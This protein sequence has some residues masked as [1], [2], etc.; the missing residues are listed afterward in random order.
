M[1]GDYYQITN[2]SELLWFAQQVNSGN[3]AINAQLTQDIDLSENGEPT[4][5]TPIGTSLNA[6]NGVFDGCG[7]TVSGYVI[8]NGDDDGAS[9]F[10]SLR[11][12]FFYNVSTDGVVQNLTVDGDISLV[13]SK[14]F[15]SKT[16]SVYVGGITSLLNGRIYNSSNTGDISIAI[17]FS[18]SRSSELSLFVGGIAAHCSSDEGEIKNCSNSGTIVSNNQFDLNKA[19]REP[20]NNIVGGIVGEISLGVVSGCTNSGIVHA[21]GAD[22]NYAGG[23]A[24]RSEKSTITACINAAE[25]SVVAENVSTN[26]SSASEGVTSAGGISG[27]GAGTKAGTIDGCVNYGTVAVSGTGKTMY[28][29]GIGGYLKNTAVTSSSNIGSVSFTDAVEANEAD[30]YVGGVVGYND[31]STKLVQAKLTNCVNSGSVTIGKV[32]GDSLYAGGIVG[33]CES[34]ISGCVNSGTITNDS[35]SEAKASGGVVG[36]CVENTASVENSTWAEETAESGIG[37]N[38]GGVSVPE[39][40]PSSEIT[41]KAV[42]TLAFESSELTLKN[43]ATSTMKIQTLPAASA[44]FAEH[45]KITGVTVEPEGI[46][47]TTYNSDGTISLT[48]NSLGTATLTVTAELYAMNYEDMTID[49]SA[50]STLTLT[51]RVTVSDRSSEGLSLS[52]AALTLE[53]GKEGTLTASLL[54]EGTADKIASVTWSSD[55]EAVATVTSSEGVS[56][57]VAAHAAGSATI[58]AAAVTT[59]GYSYEESC[60]VTVS[61]AGTP[62]PEPVPDDPTPDTPHNGGGGGGG[63]SAGFGAMALLALAPLAAMRR[64]K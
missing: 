62:A 61:E 34:A 52:P 40:K 31:Y 64:K 51:A 17:D 1:S 13:T 27:Y 45:A 39:S 18:E 10:V 35:V 15:I 59:D 16:Y 20:E 46:A 30:V 5:W 56:C 42:A 9:S 11:L 57:A 3:N 19:N 48:G 37:V 49:T 22:I 60:T 7:H 44:N 47:T 55:N 36:I 50:P 53:A 43:G 4:E 33:G 28:A 26:V 29:G 21:K 38:N 6:F 32:D 23:I 54:P 25:A 41:E 2:A 12:G 58:T 63:C 14:S 24:G 8:T